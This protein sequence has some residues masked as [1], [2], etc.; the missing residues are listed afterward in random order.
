MWVAFIEWLE[1][2]SILP[3]LRCYGVRALI[4]LL[5]LIQEFRNSRHEKKPPK[6]NW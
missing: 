4:L 6:C 3:F 1:I 2:R 5:G